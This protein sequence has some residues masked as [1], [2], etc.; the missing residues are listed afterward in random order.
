M[1][2]VRYWPKDRPRYTDGE[3]LR[4]GEAIHVANPHDRIMAPR[5][6]RF[7]VTFTVGY[8]SVGRVISWAEDVYEALEIAADFASSSGWSGVFLSTETAPD[9]EDEVIWTDSGPL[10]RSTVHIETPSD[11]DLRRIHRGGHDE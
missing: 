4:V 10:D 7:L 3:P 2:A 6:H 9:L 5:W 11:R 1:K 8:W